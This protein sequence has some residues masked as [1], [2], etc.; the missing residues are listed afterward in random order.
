MKKGRFYFFNKGER[1]DRHEHED[2]GQPLTKGIWLL[3]R[4][5]EKSLARGKDGKERW[6]P[7]M[8]LII[9]PLYNL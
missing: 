8:R 2:V 4:E 6:G 1:N 5:K 7:L 3:H 9:Y